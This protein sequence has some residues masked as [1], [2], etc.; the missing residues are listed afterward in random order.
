MRHTGLRVCTERLLSI[1]PRRLLL[2]T[3]SEIQK[4][5][6]SNLSEMVRA[7]IILYALEIRL[8]FSRKL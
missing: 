5:H 8:K 7:K 1:S 3:C 2:T 4:N 6:H